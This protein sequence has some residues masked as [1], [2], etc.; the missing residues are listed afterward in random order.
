MQPLQLK[1][2]EG[3]IAFNVDSCRRKGN[4]MS[5]RSEDYYDQNVL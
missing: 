4:L 3:G 2:E 1:Y 5:I